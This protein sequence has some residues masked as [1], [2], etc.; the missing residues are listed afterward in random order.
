MQHLDSKYREEDVA[1]EVQIEDLLQRSASS[2]D[3]IFL[4]GDLVSR[5]QSMRWPQAYGPGS[6]TKL[7][8]VVFLR[9][10]NISLTDW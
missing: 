7:Q 5:G 8:Y 4:P 9:L 2:P 3:P 6:Y 10:I 1:D